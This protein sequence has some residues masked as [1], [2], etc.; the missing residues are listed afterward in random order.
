MDGK[1]RDEVAIMVSINCITYNHEDYIEDALDSFLMQETNFEFEILIGEDCSTDNTLEIVQGYVKKHADKIRLITSDENV[2]GRAN[3]RRLQKNSKGKYIAICEGDDY[4]TDPKKLQ[5]QVD[6]MEK[7]PKCSMCF[8]AAK[9]K[10]E[11]RKLIK[12]TMIQPYRIDRISPIKHIINGGGGF[13]PT[14]SLLYPRRLMENPPKFYLTAHVGDYPLQM[15]LASE[16]YAYYISDSMAIYRTG[17]KG[18][19]T[20]QLNRERNNKNKIIEIYQQDIKLLKE[21]NEYTNFEHS[22]E[23]ENAILK[24]EFKIL[25]IMGEVITLKSSKYE[26][27]ITDLETKDKLKLYALSYFPKTYSKMI[28]IKNLVFSW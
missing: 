16:G 26:K 22:L 10:E 21:F 23:V 1:K 27:H 4:W 15:Y 6:Y 8:H 19:W 11:S 17:T 28:R 20:N 7:N 18:S 5:K 13:C 25:L 12:K 9:I 2:G 14:A 24:K 3:S